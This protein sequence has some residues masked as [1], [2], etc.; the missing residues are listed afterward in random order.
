MDP[1]PYLRGNAFPPHKRAPYPRAHLDD[2]RMP[3]DTW[4]A[5]S[6]PI[7][8]RLE[9]DAEAIEIAYRCG[10]H[11]GPWPGAGGKAFEAWRGDELLARADAAAGEGSVRLELGGPAVV[12]LPERLSPHV[13]SVE[14]DG[15]PLEPGPRWLCYGDSIAE[16]WIASSPAR[17]W[18]SIVARAH[19]LDVV[20]MGYAGAAR[21]ELPTADHI[22]SLRADVISITHGTNCWNR[23][24]FSADLMREQVRAFLA[25]VRAGHPDTPI[26]VATP[27]LRPEA[28]TTPNDR[29]A[30]MEDL[31]VAMVEACAAFDVEPIHGRDL[32]DEAMLTD[33]VHPNDAGHRAIADALGPVLAKAARR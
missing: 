27:V 7:G 16:G 5:A 11:P 13:L 24:H 1:A 31:R 3:G 18:P 28:E 15:S 30:T 9:V 29:G 12:Y 14:T 2:N 4:Y 22:A 6:L 25:T 17:A 32:I 23:V 33:N 26:V 21:G 8:V 20:N 19:S 10:G